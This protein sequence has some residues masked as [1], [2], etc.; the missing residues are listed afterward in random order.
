[1]A[2]YNFEA[3]PTLSNGVVQWQLCYLDP[4]QPAVCNSPT[5]SYPNVNVPTNHLDQSFSFKIVNDNT[6]L[7]IK[8][9]PDPVQNPPPTYVGPLWVKANN[10][11]T[12]NV[13]NGQITDVTGAGTTELQF[14]DKN[15][16]KVI[17][18]YQLNFVDMNGKKVTAIDPDIKNG[19][20]TFAYFLTGP[21]AIAIGAAIVVI[22]LVVFWNRI[23]PRVTGPGGPAAGGGNPGG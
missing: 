10:K 13:V 17:L 21:I 5:S 4:V 20:K 16:H 3:T 19:G 6:Q 2:D 1:M 11:P 9:S 7:G 15:S 8:F 23:K 12:S 14:N 18:K 22:L